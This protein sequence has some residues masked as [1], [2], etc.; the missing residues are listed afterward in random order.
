MFEQDLW[1]NRVAQGIEP[2]ARA[3]ALFAYASEANQRA[4][5]RRLTLH[6]QQASACAADAESAVAA[7]GVRPKRTAAVLL[8]KPPMG[9]S[10]ATIL[11]LPPSELADAFR[12]FVALLAIADRRRR[13]TRCSGGCPHWWHSDLRDDAA[14]IHT[15]AHSR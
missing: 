2:L 6:I 4:I 11:R 1:I 7:S 12:L 13:T 10:H 8:Q 5:L 9:V 3:E 15:R 14:I